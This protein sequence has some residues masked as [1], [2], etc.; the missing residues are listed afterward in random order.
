MQVGGSLNGLMRKQ[1]WI[2]MAC[3]Y[4]CLAMTI[5]AI[6][7]LKVKG[8][9]NL[10]KG[11]CLSLGADIVSM[12]ISTVLLYSCKQDRNLDSNYTKIFV[13]LI[14]M[15]SVLTYTDLASWLVQD[16]PELRT[17]NIIITTANYTSESILRY[18]FF[19]YVIAQLELEG[20]LVN[21]ISGIMNYLMIPVLILNL[22]NLFYPVYFYVDPMGVYSRTDLYL[23]SHAYNLLTVLV[24]LGGMV[25]ST[26]PIKTKII[27]A[28]F[29]LIPVATNLVTGINQEIT[30][31]HSAML[32][33]IVLIYGV[34]F[35]EREKTLITT[36][37]ELSMANNIQTSVIPNI[38]PAFPERQEFDVYGSM[39]AAKE[40]GGDFFDFFFIDKHHLAMVM[41]DV[42]GKGIP[43]AL[44]M[45]SAKIIIND[46]AMMG[47][48]PSEILEYANARICNKNEEEMFITVWL[49]ILDIT[50]GELTCANAG[51]EYPC[52]C[53]NG[54]FELYKDVHGFVVGAYEDEEYEDYKIKLE[55]GDYIFLYTDGLPEAN[56]AKGELFGNERM[57]EVLNRGKNLSPKEL[58]DLVKKSVEDFEKGAPQFDDLTMMAVKYKGITNSKVIP[59]QRDRLYDAMDFIDMFLSM[60]KPSEKALMEIEVAVEEIFINIASYAYPEGKGDVRMEAEAEGS[61][62]VLTLRFIDKGIPYDPLAKEDPDTTLSVEDAP[63]GGLG[64]YMLKQSMDDVSYEYKDGQN[65]LTIKKNLF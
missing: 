34:L 65:I 56:N 63:I 38:F 44:F 10:S 52:F 64:I 2:V 27:S 58:L 16:A 6:I 36:E 29:I 37:D 26:V 32:V 5:G 25:V 8:A 28:S 19:R 39:D 33:S 14:T 43:A 57:V 22:A 13:M 23:L 7:F 11:T 59:A 17:W 45:M 54:E 49:G 42:S 3:Y 9:G 48:T 21:I 18:Y 55:P 62:E 35:A 61:P 15:T 30:A 12:A 47:G 40:V 41:A 51:H 4:I 50:T 1:T 46:R 20:R 24:A 31:R 53:R 60:H